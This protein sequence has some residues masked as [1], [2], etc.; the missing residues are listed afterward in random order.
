M[1]RIAEAYDVPPN[2][3]IAAN[4]LKDPSRIKVGQV[5]FIPG[6]QT[7][8]NV[9]PANGGNP[10]QPPVNPPPNNNPRNPPFNPPVAPPPPPSACPPGA[11]AF[12]WPATGQLTSGFGMRNGRHHDGIDL[13]ASIGTPVHAAADGVVIFADRLGGYGL[14]VIIKHEGDL[15]TVYAHN[16]KNLVKKGDIVK[17]GDVVAELGNSGNAVGPHVHFE[18][19]CGQ[20]AVNPIPYLPKR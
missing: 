11:I 15:K 1:S 19:R 18:V 10:R 9:D 12:I 14:I 17:Q 7:A 2:A 20:K 4:G 16:R 6:A 3:I 8:Q 5:L 13:S